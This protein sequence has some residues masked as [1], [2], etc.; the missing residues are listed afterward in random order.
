MDGKTAPC[1]LLVSFCAGVAGREAEWAHAHFAEL[2]R[3]RWLL[4]R[5]CAAHRELEWRRAAAAHGADDPAPDSGAEHPVSDGTVSPDLGTLA[6]RLAA[7]WRRWLAGSAK[8][9]P[10]EGKAGLEG[11]GSGVPPSAFLLGDLPLPL[12]AMVYW[13][14]FARRATLAEVTRLFRDAASRAR[15]LAWVRRF[16]QRGLDAQILLWLHLLC[17][18]AAAPAPAPAR[19]ERWNDV[20]VFHGA[21]LPLLTRARLTVAAYSRPA[22]LAAEPSPSRPSPQENESARAGEGRDLI[23]LASRWGEWH[24]RVAAA[25]LA[26]DWTRALRETCALASTDACTGAVLAK[27]TQKHG[28]AE[29]SEQAELLARLDRQIAGAP[30]E[31]PTALLARMS[32]LS[33]RLAPL[34]D[35]LGGGL[36]AAAVRGAVGLAQ[37]GAP[38]GPKLVALGKLVH[39]H[40]LATLGQIRRALALFW[41]A[42][43]H[44]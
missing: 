36:G 10:D 28:V 7:R 24:A 35:E 38:A 44:G 30:L 22:D 8:P 32:R 11:A 21:P 33:E 13:A 19:A 43:G 14:S 18:T 23:D 15:P 3:P 9:G 40:S 29:G 27:S 12:S 6:P 42:V 37:K 5:R 31:D 20:A 4:L 39:A 41:L 2:A 16:A 34:A 17:A 1:D 26:A 25:D